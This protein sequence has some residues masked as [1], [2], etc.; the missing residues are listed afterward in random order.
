MSIYSTYATSA[1]LVMFLGTSDDLPEISTK[2]LLRASE[3]VKQATFNNIVSTNAAHLE[4]AKL[5]TCAQVELW[6]Q[7]GESIAIDGM[8]QSFSIGNV[9]ITQGSIDKVSGSL[10]LRARAYLNQQGLL[11]CGGSISRKNWSDDLS[12]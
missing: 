12:N 7:S 3:L 1:D 4:A 8:P 10:S 11:Y 6:L 9:S 2:L 5:A